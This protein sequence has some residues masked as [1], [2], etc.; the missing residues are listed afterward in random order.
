MSRYEL[1]TVARGHQ[2]VTRKGS[3]SGG[4]EFT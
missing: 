1:I 3:D 4:Y 2:F